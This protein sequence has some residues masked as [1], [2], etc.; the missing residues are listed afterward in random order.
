MPSRDSIGVERKIEHTLFLLSVWTKGIAG[1]VETI[2]GLLFLFIPQSG[3]NAFVI[4]LTAPELAEDPTDRVATILQRIVQ[5]LGADTKLFASSYL[6]VHGLI[7]VFLVAGLLGGRLWSYSV[8]L[9][10]LAG[11][12]AYQTYRFVFTHSLWLI[13]LNILDMIVAFLI[14]REYQV[15]K[16]QPGRSITGAREGVQ[17]LPE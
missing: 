11:F 7:K 8:S 17:Q 4:F 1:I 13:A 9:W 15:C 14:W 2:G 5:E 12:I 3:L 16:G 6:I 10:F